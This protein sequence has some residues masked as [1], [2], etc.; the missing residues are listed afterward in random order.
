MQA[1]TAAATPP[2][3][4]HQRMGRRPAATGAAR[5]VRRRRPEPAL[6]DAGRDPS[7]L[8]GALARLEWSLGGCDGR[9]RNRLGGYSLSDWKGLD[10]CSGRFER[11]GRSRGFADRCRLRHRI[12]TRARRRH[13]DQ[14]RVA[15]R[16]R[17]ATDLE[18]AIAGVRPDTSVRLAEEE[19]GVGRPERLGTQDQR[20]LPGLGEE[21]VIE[22]QVGV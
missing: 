14:V 6:R 10:G 12:G 1:S 17:A 8:A 5:P 4:I 3:H 2:S 21:A 16:A 18:L 9:H 22:P 20:D 7:G 13:D 15:A 19:A 11:D